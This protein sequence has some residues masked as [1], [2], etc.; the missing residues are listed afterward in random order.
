MPSKNKVNPFEL[1][2]YEADDV[3]EWGNNDWER[4]VQY[5]GD[6]ERI[7]E[8]Y[9]DGT[10]PL[11]HQNDNRQSRQEPRSNGARAFS[12][13]HNQQDLQRNNCLHPQAWKY[14]VLSLILVVAL[15]FVN[16]KSHE[17]KED[18]QDYVSLIDEIPNDEYRLVILGERHSGTSWLHSRLQECFPHAFVSTTL[19]RPGCFFQDEPV[20]DRQEQQQ[21]TI[22]IH[23]TLNIYDWLELMRLSPE[24]APNHVRHAE[25]NIVPLSWREFL[26]TSWTMDRPERDIPFGNETEPVCQLGFRYNQVISC[27]VTPLG[28]TDNPVYELKDDGSAYDSIISMRAAKLQ[29]HLSVQQWESVKKFIGLSYENAAKEFKSRIITEIQHFTGWTPACSGDVLPPSRERSISM[30]TQFV[31]Y[32]T[33]KAIWETEAAVSYAPWTIWDVNEKGIKTEKGDNVREQLP[34]PTEV[35]SSKDETSNDSLSNGAVTID[36]AGEEDQQ[37]DGDDVRDGKQ[38]DLSEHTD[39]DSGTDETVDPAAKPSTDSKKETTTELA[40]GGMLSIDGPSQNTIN[41]TGEVP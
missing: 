28:G 4:E 32:V 40:P 25:G 15:L 3:Y 16:G 2:D 41:S 31:E 19:Q 38:D 29:N 30:S 35:P 13:Y 17:A 23:L 33:E 20:K 39:T 27:A 14:G 22:V 24:Y 1:D 6:K 21:D 12:S 5:A 26:A 8:E 36:S 34:D 18:E 7:V 9:G 10:T 37:A 11:S